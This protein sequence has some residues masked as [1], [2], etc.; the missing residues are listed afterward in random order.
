[1]ESLSSNLHDFL[2]KVGENLS[3][4]DKKFLRDTLIGL[5]RSDQPIVCQMAHQLP[6]Q[7]TKFLLRL[8]RLEEHLL[9]ESGFDDEV[10]E[11]LPQ[12]WLPFAGDDMLIIL[13]LSDLA[14]PKATQMDYLAIVRDG[15]GG[16]LV[17]GYWL[18]E[19]YTSVSHKNPVSILLEPF[20]HQEPYSPG[21]NPVVLKA[22]E[23]IFEITDKR[24]VLIA[25]RDLTLV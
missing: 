6:N 16:E 18:V 15:S 8:D 20:S 3:L 23:R 9:S 7:H 25:D 12:V 22:V 10:K 2:K 13:D 14:K 17:N 5:I 19:A 21:Q 11:T 4:P 24:G 1:M